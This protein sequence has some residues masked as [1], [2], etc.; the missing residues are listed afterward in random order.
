MVNCHDSASLLDPREASLSSSADRE[1]AQAAIRLEKGKRELLSELSLR[2]V[3]FPE[4]RYWITIVNEEI[5][6]LESSRDGNPWNVVLLC[7]FR[8]ADLERSRCTP[9]RAQ[10]IPYFRTGGISTGAESMSSSWE[11]YAVFVLTIRSCFHRARRHCANPP[12]R[13]LSAHPS[14]S[15]WMIPSLHSRSSW[16]KMLIHSPFNPYLGPNLVG[17]FSSGLRISDFNKYFSSFFF[18]TLLNVYGGIWK[19]R[20]IRFKFQGISLRHVS[21]I[22]SVWKMIQR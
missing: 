19:E 22:S 20:Q 13:L 8:P 5:H 4:A 12:F 10:T 7:F 1:S 17:F 9:L 18:C 6:R 15:R 14:L 21:S 16:F 3:R 11:A 2:T